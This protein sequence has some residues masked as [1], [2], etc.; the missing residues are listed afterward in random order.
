MAAVSAYLESIHDMRNMKVTYEINMVAKHG[1]TQSNNDIDDNT[2][3]VSSVCLE[4]EI[5]M[6]AIQMKILTPEEGAI[7]LAEIRKVIKEA[8]DR[9][10]N[11]FNADGTPIITGWTTGTTRRSWSS[12]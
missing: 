3:E 11:M 7:R 1:Y 8:T 4:E 6:T 9:E 10:I 2:S 5:I 12:N